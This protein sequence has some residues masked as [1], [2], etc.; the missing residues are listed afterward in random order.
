MTLRQLVTIAFSLCCAGAVFPSLA[1]EK[2]NANRLNV[3]PPHI[4]VDKSIKWDYDIVYVRAPRFG[5]DKVSRWAEVFNPLNVD[6]GADLVLLHPD[7]S[8]EVLVEGGEGAIADPYVSFDGQWVYYAKFHDQTQQAASGFPRGGSD[9]YKIHLGTRKIVRLTHQERT[10]NTGI[11]TAEE[12][13]GVP[14]F[15]LGPC[16][17]PG[18]RVVFTSNR[19]LF[20]APKMYTR[21]SFQLFAMDEDGANVEMIGHL[22]IASAL[23]PVI[24]RDGRVMFSSYESQ[25]LR[26]LRN[27]GLWFIYPDGTGWGPIVSSFQR[28]DVYHFHTQVS[29]GSI[30]FEGYYNLNNSGFGTL[31]RMPAGPQDN[32]A[33]FGPADRNS[34]RNPP[35]GNTRRPRFSYTPYGLESLTRFVSSFDSPAELSNR[36][37]PAS[38]RVGKFTHP[39]GAPENHLLVVWSP[40]AVNSNGS[41]RKDRN[42]QIDSGIY[43]IRGTEAIDEP[44]DMLLIKNDPKY[45]EQWPRPVVPYER[46]YGVS[47]PQ[48]KTPPANDGTASPHLA[49]GSP[50][51]L[52]GTS[53][54]YKRESITGGVV[55]DGGVTAVHVGDDKLGGLQPFNKYRPEIDHWF[56]QGSDCGLYE[57]AEIH[58]IRILAQEPTTQQKRMFWNWGSERYRILGE[59]PVRKFGRK[60]ATASGDGQPLDPDGNPD[61]SFLV[62][63]PADTSFTFQTL[64]KHGMSLNMAQTWHQVR[65]GEVRHD[66][67]GCHAHS[68]KPTPFAQ[69]AAAR[70]D[71]QVLDL[72][73]QTPLLTNK[74]LDES[75]R[76]WDTEDE[77]GLRFEERGAVDVEFFRHIVPIFEKSCIA[78]HSG[79]LAKPAAGLVLDDME[80]VPGAG[81]GG[82]FREAPG[83][84]VPGTYAMLAMGKVDRHGHRHVNGE[85]V[86]PQM[87]RYVRIYQSRRS[88]LAWKVLNKRT[89]GWS[90]DDFPTAATPGDA[91]T[92]QIGGEPISANGVNLERADVDLTGSVMPPPAAVKAGKVQPLTEEDRRTIFRWI[93]LGCPIDIKYDPEKPGG[94][95]PGSGWMDDEIRP[96]LTMTLPRVRNNDPLDRI[97]IGMH[98][99][100]SGLDMDSFSVTADFEIAGV[101]S[102][103]NLA[104]RFEPLPE[105]RWQWKLPAPVAE[106][107]AG[108]LTVSVKDRKGNISRIERKFRVGHGPIPQQKTGKERGR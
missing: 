18:G 12:A 87:S 47:E 74:E 45:N 67:G 70:E 103:Q 31:Y 72:A 40:G 28:A 2:N 13:Q 36:S 11:L 62:R 4:S 9:I 100:Y 102:G 76:Q 59:V 33:A 52:V 41:F 35:Q 5:D 39:C 19:N 66:C 53:S 54:M 15:N 105:N 95:G 38:P 21:G 26:D 10:P 25:G 17:A 84:K 104:P 101:A 56:S 24:L 14:V 82:M 34:D 98:D 42:P 23:H 97:L 94:S 49:E 7:G 63:I 88:L 65:P 75:K 73:L 43:L 1:E 61:T 8:E 78:C 91:A 90:N 46:I 58:A 44:A 29:D 64:D 80:M 83:G 37:D 20:E 86:L 57:N 93:D 3:Q 50:F 81:G 27:W 6:P 77:T 68:Q 107:P 99:F 108:T 96:T 55:P 71:Y 92:L 22:N 51:G 30:V 69:T 32:Y 79:Q 60:D 48:Y 89:D 16:P 85:W 106:L